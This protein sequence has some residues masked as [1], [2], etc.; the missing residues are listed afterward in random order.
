MGSLAKFTQLAFID[1][2]NFPGGPSAF[3]NDEFSIPV[4]E[5]GNVAFVLNNWLCDAVIV[6]T[7]VICR[8]RLAM[9]AEFV[10][11]VWRCMV[12]Y[13]GCRLPL[14]AIMF[15]PCL[16]FLASFGTSSTISFIVMDFYNAVWLAMG[17]MW[18][19]QISSSGPFENSSINWTIPYFTLSLSLNILVT[20]AIVLRLL[21]Y[22]HRIAGVLGSSHGSQYTSIAAM[23]VESAAIYSVFSICF[24]IP[25]A[26]NS[27]ISQIFLQALG[28]VQTSSTL[29]IIF[30][31]AQGKGW[32][33]KAQ[34]TFLSEMGTASASG[35][36]RTGTSFQMNKVSHVQFRTERSSKTGDSSLTAFDTESNN[37]Y[38]VPGGGPAET[39]DSSQALA[40]F[41]SV[42]DEDYAD[43]PVPMIPGIKVS[44]DVYTDADLDSNSLSD[45]QGYRYS[46]NGPR[47]PV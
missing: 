12:I 44:R 29:L 45:Q 4:D 18:L 15:S 2:R 20:I 19:L 7:S 26:L 30:R 21:V 42:K 5:L 40:S 41:G 43:S 37:R 8:V 36:I 10:W 9:V 27:S 35:G 31:V 3:E 6:S 38:I 11:Q 17:L 33:S 46:P 34:S 13:K 32:S 47:S 1:N 22:R 23:I 25:F 39:K 16:L 14:W 24:L 28:Q